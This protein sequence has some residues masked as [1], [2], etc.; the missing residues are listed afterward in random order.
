M[1]VDVICL[2]CRICGMRRPSLIA[3]TPKRDSDMSNRVRKLVMSLSTFSTVFI[4]FSLCGICPTVVKWIYPSCIEKYSGVYFPQDKLKDF[5]KEKI[6]IWGGSIKA[7]AAS[8]GL[9]ETYI[10]DILNGKSANPSIYKV[11]LLADALNY[12]PLWNG[13]SYNMLK[14][15]LSPHYIRSTIRKKD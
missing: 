3:L 13:A 7:L 6:D 9:K 2:P 15:G 8:A 14:S 5:I 4:I 10:N 12:S 11:A 1:V